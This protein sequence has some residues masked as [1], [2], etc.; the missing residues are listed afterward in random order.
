MPALPLHEAGAY[1][2]GAYAVF[3]TVLMAYV[4]IMSRNV[5]GVRREVADLRDELAHD[6]ED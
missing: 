5:D 1:V 3:A 2:A 6:D 4:G